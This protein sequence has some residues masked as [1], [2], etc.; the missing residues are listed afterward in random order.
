MDLCNDTKP[1]GGYTMTGKELV[2]ATFRHEKTDA[3]PWVPFA[4]VHAGKLIGADATEVYTDIDILTKAL[5]EAHRLYRPDGQ[6]V[7]FDLQIEAEALGCELV[8]AKNTPATVSSHP[9]GSSKEIPDKTVGPEDGR[10][11]I[12][13]EATRRL[14][15]EV[16]DTTAIYGLFCG[17]FTLASHLRGTHIFMDFKRDPEY[18][19]KLL[20]YATRVN[21]AMAD[22]Y[23][24]AGADI[25]A[26][27]D[28]L[29]SQISPKIFTQFMHEP[30]IKLN[31]HIRK[32]GRYSSFFVCGD[33]TKN[34]EVMCETR[35]DGISVDENLDFVKTKEITDRY[36]I[37]LGGSIPLAT[38]MLF[39]TQQDNMIKVI[40]ELDSVSHH[41]LIVSPGC[42]MPY[43]T[44][45]ENTIGCEQ[46]VHQ[47]DQTRT[48]IKGYE[49]VDQDIEIS[50]PD[51]KNLKR[52]LIEVF[53]IDS[54][55]CAACTYMFQSAMDAKKKY[56]EGLDIIEYKASASL[57]NIV[58]AQKMGVKQLPSIYINGE[59]KFSSIIP[60]SDAL[61]EAIEAAR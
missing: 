46:A 53:T 13:M 54:D 20:D 59:L 9:L 18:L 14:K 4:G 8:W 57:E 41:N 32:L 37:V 48:L 35:P 16:G 24:E 45:V 34:I 6:T 15:R 22:M 21:I 42:D 52:P 29:I 3:V 58:R 44:P 11:P 17:P 39:G 49:K 33:A 38:V 56:G 7:M 25:I 27:V 30:Y 61:N 1:E 51:Y 2:L 60:G 28:P 23:A 40:E 55:T 47:T 43:D 19:H 31:E 36:N 26:P 5:L 50:L 12:A 10:I